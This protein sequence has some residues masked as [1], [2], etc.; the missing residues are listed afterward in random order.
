M[1]DEWPWEAR[2]LDPHE[3]YNEIRYPSR[4][5][6]F[7]FSKPQLSE[8]TVLPYREAIYDFSW[9]PDM[10]GPKIL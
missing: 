7:G 2:E 8:T 10:P 3:P 4:P 5:L 6:G 9:K 1:G